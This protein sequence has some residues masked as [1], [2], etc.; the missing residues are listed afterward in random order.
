[1]QGGSSSDNNRRHWDRI[2]DNSEEVLVSFPC[3]DWE[4]FLLNLGHS[5]VEAAALEEV[6]LVDLEHRK[7]DPYQIVGNHMA[8]CGMKAYEH[9]KS[10][11]DDIFKGAKTYEEVLD[12]VQTLPSDLQTS[13]LTF[14]RHRRSGF[15][16]VLQ[17]EATTPPLEQENTPP[18]FGQK[19]QDKADTEENPQGAKRSSQNEEVPQ[20]ENPGVET[21]RRSGTPPK[22]SQSTPPSSSTV[23]V[24]TPKTTGETKSTELDNPIASLTPLQSTFGLPQMGVIYASDLTPI[25]REEIPPSDYFFSKKRKVVLK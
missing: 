2:K 24:D 22:S 19:A 4:V 25:S 17:G 13:F 9:E 1:V 11:C 15:P 18:G 6:K 5:K 8:H 12:K 16:K 21:E 7:H 23:H 14:Q 3:T 10:P 20:I